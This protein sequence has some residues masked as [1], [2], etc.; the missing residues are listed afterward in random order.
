MLFVTESNE[1]NKER[2]KIDSF[3]SFN[4]ITKS[5]KLQF[6]KIERK[7]LALTDVKDIREEH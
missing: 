6:S 5:T 1:L 2:V 7:I 3:Y 4:S